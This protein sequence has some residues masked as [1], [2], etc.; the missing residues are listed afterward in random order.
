MKN[1][2]HKGPIGPQK[3]RLKPPGE[4]LR[5]PV[6]ESSLVVAVLVAAMSLV[7]GAAGRPLRLADLDNR[8]VNPFDAPEGVKAIVFVFTSIDCP[9]SNRYA[10][11]IRRISD[12]FA[13]TGVRFWMV[14]PN[15]AES[16]KAIRTHVTDFAYPG[17]VLRDPQQDLVKL[18]KA[19]V[20]PEAAVFDRDERLLYHGRI[21]DRFVS[22]GL[23]RPAP[24]TH[25][26]EDAISAILGGRRV[27][28]ASAQAVG[29]FLADFVR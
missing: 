23:E 17:G 26:L 2:D 28:P 7:A 16:A 25:D 5:R 13:A 18:A 4:N 3:P 22:L 11:E 27:S 24:T 15:P 9:V 10:P 6:C 1:D 19:T 20:T 21:D 12:T 14:Y 29:C 8:L